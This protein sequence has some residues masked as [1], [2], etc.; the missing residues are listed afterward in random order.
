MQ[1]KIMVES[2]N[3]GAWRFTQMNG[4]KDFVE[5]IDHR[6]SADALEELGESLRDKFTVNFIFEVM[7]D[8]LCWV[9]V[10]GVSTPFLDLIIVQ[11]R[12]HM[13]QDG[14]NDLKSLVL[15]IVA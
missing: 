14:F 12:F 13:I 10:S 7:Q 8:L 11:L 2:C 6:K 5:V 1:L 9:P 15:L 3:E 4:L